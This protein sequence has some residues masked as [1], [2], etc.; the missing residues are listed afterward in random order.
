MM[1]KRCVHPCLKPKEIHTPDS[2]MGLGA[3]LVHSLSLVKTTPYTPLLLPFYYPTYFLYREVTY[4]LIREVNGVVNWVLLRSPMISHSFPAITRPAL[5]TLRSHIHCCTR[6]RQPGHRPTHDIIIVCSSCSFLFPRWPN[7]KAFNLLNPTHAIFI[8]FL[9][10]Q[11]HDCVVEI[12]FKLI[13]S[14]AEYP[15]ARQRACF[16]SRTY[17]FCSLF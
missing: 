17:C 12:N 2:P 4:C 9:L 1:L 3:F 8:H 11:S 7:H 5:P 13:L 10:T 15:D 14:F 16:S 6:H